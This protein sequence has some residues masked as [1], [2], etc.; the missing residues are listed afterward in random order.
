MELDEGVIKYNNSSFSLEPPLKAHQI[1]D[2]ESWREKLFTRNLIGE[3]PTEKVG[4]GNLSCRMKNGNHF[5]I[6]GTQTGKHPKLLPE[7]YTTVT[8]VNL[9]KK[10]VTA[11]GPIQ[12]SSEAL[13]HAAIYQCGPEIL[14]VFHI[15]S[16]AI[17]EGMIKDQLPSTQKSTP[18]GTLE[19]A[20]EVQS[21]VGSQKSGVIVMKGHQD[22]VIAYGSS[23]NITGNLILNLFETYC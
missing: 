21:L 4:F 2:L 13:T 16:K 9:G 5:I 12:A 23:L 3:Y 17:W 8:E 18:Y 19:M 11:K 6:T 14:A 10:S 22:G 7:H 15:H 1:E 20:V